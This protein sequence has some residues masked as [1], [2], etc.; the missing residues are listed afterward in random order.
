MNRNNNIQLN[1]FG[2]ENKEM[3][4]NKFMT[5]MIKYPYTAIPKMIEKIHFNDNYPENKNIRMLNKRDNKLQVQNNT[6][7]DYVHKNETIRN[8]IDEQNYTMDKFFTDNKD[9]FS[10][11]HQKRYNGFQKKMDNDD[12]KTVKN[13]YCVAKDVFMAIARACSSRTTP[14]VRRLHG[15]ATNSKTIEHPTRLSP[16]TFFFVFLTISQI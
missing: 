9:T 10:E 3:L 2:E 5:N 4:T 12:S 7:W 6:R 15:N 1:N 16:E 11:L 13:M 14:K 8:L